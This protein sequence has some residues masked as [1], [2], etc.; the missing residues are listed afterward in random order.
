MPIKRDYGYI[1]GAF[2]RPGGVSDNAAS[3]ALV[4]E[5]VPVRPTFGFEFLN[6]GEGPLYLVVIDG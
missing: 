2:L 1:A 3:Q 4:P 6:W 5:A